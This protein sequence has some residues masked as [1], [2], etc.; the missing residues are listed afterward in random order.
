MIRPSIVVSANDGAYKSAFVG[1]GAI[2]IALL[3]EILPLKDVKD[4]DFDVVRC[5]LPQRGNKLY[6]FLFFK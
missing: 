1:G 3:G 4:E 5:H 2:G 6:I